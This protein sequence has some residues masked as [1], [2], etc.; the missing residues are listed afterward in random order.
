MKIYQDG[1]E[2]EDVKERGAPAVNS[3]EQYSGDWHI[4]GRVTSTFE[5]EIDEVAVFNVVL[6]EKDIN[7]IMNKGIVG[8]LA[9]SLSGKLAITWGRLR[10]F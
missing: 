1:S 8:T 4:G 7:S 3:F 2:V 6:T 5:G 9:V 10:A